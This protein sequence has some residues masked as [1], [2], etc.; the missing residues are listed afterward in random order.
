[1][2]R[3]TE[4]GMSSC[5][6]V[7]SGSWVRPHRKNTGASDYVS[8]DFSFSGVGVKSMYITQTWL[9]P[10]SDTWPTEVIPTQVVTNTLSMIR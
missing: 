6:C 8:E 3:F 1:M 4:T 10:V 9:F 7:N 2:A 5:E